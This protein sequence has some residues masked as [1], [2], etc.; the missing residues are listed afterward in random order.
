MST[1]KWFMYLHTYVHTTHTHTSHPLP[2]TTTTPLPHCPTCKTTKI[3]LKML[4]I[5][6]EA[7]KLVE[8]TGAKVP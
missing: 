6:H 3:E 7:I 8:E 5:R 1:H 4:N 2:T